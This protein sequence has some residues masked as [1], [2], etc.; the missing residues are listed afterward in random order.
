MSDRTL[1]IRLAVKDGE[2][3]H[4]SWVPHQRDTGQPALIVKNAKHSQGRG[5]QP[6]RRFQVTE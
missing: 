2:W 5:S 3:R 6:F 4:A 1:A